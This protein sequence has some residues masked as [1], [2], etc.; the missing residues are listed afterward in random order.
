[1]FPVL[2][3]VRLK[4]ELRLLHASYRDVERLLT[5][6][7]RELQARVPEVSSWS[8]AQQ[9]CHI[10]LVNG[11]VF[12]N[13]CKILRAEPEPGSAQGRP[14]RLGRLVLLFRWIPRG[15][16]RAPEA[17][18]P[19]DTSSAEE[20][21]T[22]LK[23]SLEELCEIESLSSSGSARAKLRSGRRHHFAFGDLN[24]LEWL[25]FARIHTRHHLRIIR[26]IRRAGR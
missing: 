1:M 13:I 12:E 10:F 11:A 15:K 20:L 17:V 19:P 24:A 7:A 5:L 14:T 8:T 25:R 16:G 26:D 4:S 3:P 21:A 22:R 18:I 9:I 2:I 23:E 6:G